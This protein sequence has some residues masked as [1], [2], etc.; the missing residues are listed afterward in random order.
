MRIGLFAEPFQKPWNGRPG[1]VKTNND[2]NKN[3]WSVGEDEM[4]LLFRR[5]KY[6]VPVPCLEK[7]RKCKN[8]RDPNHNLKK[9]N[10]FALP[11]H[12]CCMFKLRNTGELYMKSEYH[13]KRRYEEI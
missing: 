1:S 6:P 10:Y 11:F 4:F 12:F 7:N 13:Y 3:F 8:E 2:R 5:L 9:R